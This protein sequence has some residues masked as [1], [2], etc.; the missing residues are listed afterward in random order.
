MDLRLLRSR[1]G[2]VALSPGERAYAGL[3]TFSMLKSEA[4]SVRHTIDATRD[5]A[6]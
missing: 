4:E 3:G 6:A 5:A 1:A 2:C